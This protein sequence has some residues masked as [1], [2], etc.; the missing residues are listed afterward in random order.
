M[1]PGDKWITRKLSMRGTLIPV[2]CKRLNS[3]GAGTHNLRGAEK[4]NA[5][6]FSSFQA[7]EPPESVA[8]GP[9]R[10]ATTCHLPFLL[11]QTSA[12]NPES[13]MGLP[14]NVPFHQK[15]E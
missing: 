14:S 9:L 3:L 7:Q 4:T 10:R 13:M 1:A 6:R 12:R 2:R 5:A 15:R 11:T 8:E